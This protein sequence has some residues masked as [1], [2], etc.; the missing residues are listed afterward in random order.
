M[1]EAMRREDRIAQNE[2]LFREVNE[3]IRDVAPEG[4][5]P[6]LCECGDDEC[7]ETIVLA[8]D[9]YEAV[10]GASEQFVVRRGHV[11][12]DVE[13]VVAEHDGYVVVHK[14]E[15]EA[16]IARATHPRA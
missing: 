1:P 15:D 13:S 7:V 5:A 10:R 3:R 12:T 11:A 2:A 6:F 8:E 9:E 4:G 14:H 16:A